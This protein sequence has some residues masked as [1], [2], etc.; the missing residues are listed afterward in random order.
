[1]KNQ[2][3]GDFKDYMKYGILR[4]L[5]KC[6]FRTHLCWMLTEVDG[7]GDGGDLRTLRILP[8]GRGA[9]IG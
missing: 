4:C 5:A 3:V 7:S 8:S 2:H 9:A 1:M 6:G